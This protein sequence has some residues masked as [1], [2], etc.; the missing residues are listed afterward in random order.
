MRSKEKRQAQQPRGTGDSAEHR[1]SRPG[2]APDRNRSS[3]RAGHVPHRLPAPSPRLLAAMGRPHP[4]PQPA[5]PAAAHR[6]ASQRFDLAVTGRA[7][8]GSSLLARSNGHTWASNPPGPRRTQPSPSPRHS[9][10]PPTRPTRPPPAAAPAVGAAP[11]APAVGWVL[12]PP[13]TPRHYLSIAQ[14]TPPLTCSVILAVA[15]RGV[16]RPSKPAQPGG[17]NRRRHDSCL[18]TRLPNL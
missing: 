9:H 14:A 4:P 12:H 1:R 15:L 5:P 10:G 17:S 13:V 8:L 7:L 3:A 16:T 2:R 6:L 18:S 11:A